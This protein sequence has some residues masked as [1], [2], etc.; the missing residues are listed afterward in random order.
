MKAKLQEH[1]G[2]KI[3]ITD[4]NGKANVVTFRSTAAVIINEFY[5]YRGKI[6]KQKI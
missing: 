3:I 4:I 1:F 5:A 6:Q 2:N